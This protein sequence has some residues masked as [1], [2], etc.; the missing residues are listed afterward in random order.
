V[1][2]IEMSPQDQI[3]LVTGATGGIGR[4][5]ASSLAA[6]GMTLALAGRDARSL[7]TLVS[8]IQRAGVRA[9]S[10]RADISRVED[11]GILASE[12]KNKLGACDVLVHA[13]GVFRMGPIS[14][15]SVEELDTLYQTNVRGPYALTQ[16][17]LPMLVA[18]RGQIVFIN[19]T[20][21]LAARAGI[22]AYAASKHA[23]KAIADSLREEVNPLGVRVISVYP[24]R[25]ATPQQEKIYEQ[26]GRPYQPE[27]LLQPEDI[28][29]AVLNALTMPRTAEVTDINIR[30]MQKS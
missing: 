10:F 29:K 13:A 14:Q 2:Q 30:P 7:E 20:V 24:G 25:T 11:V 8:Q 27:L 23:L 6:A 18:R 16:A 12:V 17:L 15:A 4:A 21:G 1:G 26:E 5:I 22:A 9:E 28:A 3:G 19:S